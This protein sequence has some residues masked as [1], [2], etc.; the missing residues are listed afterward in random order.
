[1][2]TLIWTRGERMPL[3]LLQERPRYPRCGNRNIQG[4]SHISNKPHARAAE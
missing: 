3:S 4:L 1:M 2:V